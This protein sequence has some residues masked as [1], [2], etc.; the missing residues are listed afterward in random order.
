MDLAANSRSCFILKL[1]TSNLSQIDI[2]CQTGEKVKG[3]TYLKNAARALGFSKN[4]KEDGGK[5]KETLQALFKI[6]GFTE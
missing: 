3:F 4:I 1:S 2:T 6:A 5:Q